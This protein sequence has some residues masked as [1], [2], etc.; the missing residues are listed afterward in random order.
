LGV[1]YLWIDSLCILQDS[2]EDWQA[3]SLAI[4]LVYKN[5][6]CNI[7]ASGPHAG[8]FSVRDLFS[9]MPLK[10]YF[11]PD[12]ALSEKYYCFYDWWTYVREETPISRQGWVVQERLLS[13]YTIYFSIPIFWECRELVAYESYPKG[14]SYDF[15]FSNKIWSDKH[16]EKDAAMRA[17]E[18]CIQIFSECALTKSNNKFVAIA[19]IAKTYESALGTYLAGIW[20]SNIVRGLLWWVNKDRTRVRKSSIRVL[21]YRGGSTL[22]RYS[23]TRK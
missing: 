15:N 23:M 14:V 2:K 6:F 12:T 19:G 4:Y 3:E 16:I 1:R 9:L 5:S 11:N 17:W 21:P 10:L 22:I 18:S 13:P 8:L 20:S 7:A